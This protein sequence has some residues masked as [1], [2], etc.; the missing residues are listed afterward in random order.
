MMVSNPSPK[1]YEGDGDRFMTIERSAPGERIVM[2]P[3][4]MP[5]EVPDVRRQIRI[6]WGQHLLE[7]LLLGRYHSFV[8]AVNA[9]DNTHGII[10]QIAAMLP[11][12]QWNEQSVTAYA[13]RFSGGPERVKI[14][15]YEMDMLEVLAILRPPS[16][17]HLTVDHLAS[18]FR[19]ISEM[20]RHR[21]T[22]LPT[23]SV[24]FLGARANLLVDERGVEPSFETV[25][26]TMHE[27]GF[28]GDVYPAPAMWSN[29]DLGVYPRYP[30]PAALDQ[31]RDGGS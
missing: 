26:R 24:S 20:I 9:R 21:T 22:R 31:M 27:A 1:V 13:V 12:T 18:A 29:P 19:I 6:M 4:G 7:D 25:L 17:V 30:F 16:A 23:A 8:C 3:D 10:G 5:R 14:I 28:Y 15:K 11:T 2:I